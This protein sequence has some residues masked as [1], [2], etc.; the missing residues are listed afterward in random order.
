MKKIAHFTLVL[1]AFVFA[2]AL[3]T[4]QSVEATV[5][6]PTFVY[7]FKYNPQNESV[8]FVEHSMSGRG[9]PP[10]L[11]KISL[12]TS[13]VETVYSCDE[14]EELMLET[15]S[16]DNELVLAEIRDI[17]ADFKD[18]SQINLSDNKISVD[19]DLVRDNYL[20][21]SPDWLL[22]RDFV[23]TIY[24]SGKEVLRQEVSGCESDQ[25]FTY[26][27]YAIPGFEKK[28]IMLVSRT[29][30]CFEGGYVG[31][32]LLVVGGLND[33]DK[34]YATNYQKGDS[35]LIASEA[36][37]VVFEADEATGEEVPEKEPGK[38]QENEEDERFPTTAMLAI[39]LAVFVL[40]LFAGRLF[41]GKNSR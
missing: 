17:T 37:L 29:E 40:G 14:G 9:C 32:E 4:G 22:G 26:A 13:K 19:I 27:G 35:A 16:Y 23:A 36:T 28:I 15:G 20:E 1:S 24:Q 18:L 39:G 8:Y 21:G 25:S 33:L 34:S 5:G 11:K 10:E 31:E 2:T 6:G 30:D 3:F 41:L 12:N 7:S 38:E